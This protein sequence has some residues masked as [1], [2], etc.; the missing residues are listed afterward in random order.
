VPRLPE[1]PNI[2]LVEEQAIE[3]LFLYESNDA[4]AFERFRKSLPA[5]EGKDDAAIAALGLGLEDAQLCIAREYNLPEWKNLKNYIDW[6]SS[7]FSNAREDAVPLWLHNVYGHETDPPRPKLAAQMRGDNVNGTL[8]WASR[9]H[10]PDEGDWVGCARALVEH[11]MPILEI[12]G[13]YSDEVGQ[14]LASERA[15]LQGN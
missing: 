15:R 10:D 2:D 12:D 4:G 9:N 7:R 3:L 6:R 13:D 1:N 11:G 5:A 14:F 8:S